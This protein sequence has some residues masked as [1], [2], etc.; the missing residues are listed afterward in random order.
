[1]LAAV[2]S[3]ALDPDRVQSFR[4]LQA[5]AAYEERR[6]DPRARAAAVSDRK[7]ALKTM[8]YHHKYRGED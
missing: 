3:G 1:V 5:E 7:T 6:A 8:K 4:K 2:E